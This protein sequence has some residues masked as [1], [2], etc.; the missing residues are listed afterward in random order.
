MPS[1]E[2]KPFFVL[3]SL[4]L[5]LLSLPS[6]SNVYIHVQVYL[7][8]CIV[9]G[10]ITGRCTLIRNL[11]KRPAFTS[12]I[13]TDQT[14][15]SPFSL[16][17]SVCLSLLSSLSLFL[18]VRSIDFCRRELFGSARSHIFR[19][20]WANPCVAN[21]YAR[22]WRPINCTIEAAAIFFAFIK[23][24]LVLYRIIGIYYIL[25]KSRG[26]GLIC[27]RSRKEKRIR[28]EK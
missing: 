20:K 4:S 6:P 22:I 7:I 17:L 11:Q 26:N 12:G 13:T 1:D 8:L 14:L 28:R 16:S 9:C 3:P 19:R 10:S 23:H 25:Y 2:N 15:F 27:R 24:Q 5:I 18:L 21:N